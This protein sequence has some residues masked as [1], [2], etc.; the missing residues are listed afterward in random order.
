MATRRAATFLA[1]A[2]A[3]CGCN[4]L[5]GLDDVNIEPGG[6]GGAGGAPATTA[7]P[8]DGENTSTAPQGGGGAGPAG[9]GPMGGEAGGGAA[10]TGGGAGSTGGSDTTSSGSGGAT[11]STTSSSTTTTSS[12]GGGDTTSSTSAGSGAGGGPVTPCGDGVVDDGEQCDDGDL[13]SGDGCSATCQVEPFYQCTVPGPSSCSKQEVLCNDGTDNDGDTLVDFEDTDCALPPYAPPLPCQVLRIYRSVNIPRPIPDNGA[14][15]AQSP[16]FVPDDFSIVHTAVLLDI[17]H[18]RVSDLDGTLV[19]PF[20]QPRD[21]TSDNGG[22]GSHYKNTLFDSECGTSVTAGSAPFQG[23]FKPESFLP[24]SGQQAK[25]VW[26][27]AVD[28]YGP[29]QSGTLQS[30][31]LVLCAP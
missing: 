17:T 1:A 24:A 15:D 14:G 8:G 9:G 27:L 21:L 13:A 23:C 6:A 7:L 28:D 10:S 12:T 22:N 18:G 31:A 2:A 16:I 20:G 25:G 11:S 3:L 19:P 26:T 29:G 30:W 5:I 4:V